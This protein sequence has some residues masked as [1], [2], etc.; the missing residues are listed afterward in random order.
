VNQLVVFCEGATEQGFCRQVLQSHLFPA[1][2]G[3]IHTF[4]VGRKDDRHVYGVSRKYGPLRKF[5]EN[6][7]KQNRPRTYFTSLIDLYGLPGDFPGKADCSRNPANPTPYVLALEKA[8]AE[9]IGDWRF[10]P[11]LQLHEYETMLFADPAGFACSFE[12]CETQIN[13]LIKIADSY[14]TIEHINDRWE[15]A[16]S[17]QIEN[18]LPEYA[19]RKA[20]AGPDIAEFIGLPTIRSKC[21]HF[22]EWLACLEQLAWSKV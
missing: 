13:A 16:P 7:L 15:T 18:A 20:S 6:T 12:N 9:D 21:P 3:M 19:G 5:I 2:D 14:S 17:R 10:I 11:Y 4:A 8:F 22:N 1:H